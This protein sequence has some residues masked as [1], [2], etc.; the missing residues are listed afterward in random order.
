MIPHMATLM[1][2]VMMKSVHVDICACCKRQ[3]QAIPFP[4]KTGGSTPQTHQGICGAEP[5]SFHGRGVKR[6]RKGGV[7]SPPP[8]TPPP[9]PNWGVSFQTWPT[10]TLPLS[11]SLSHVRWPEE[12]LRDMPNY[13]DGCT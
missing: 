10:H 4:P 8:R 9:L 13:S 1:R 12:R 11:L 7:G 3:S 6:V 2:Y 5:P